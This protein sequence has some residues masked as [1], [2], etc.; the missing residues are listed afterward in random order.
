MPPNDFNNIVHSLWRLPTASSSAVSFS[1]FTLLMS[2]PQSSTSQR[3]KL[4]WPLKADYIKQVFPLSSGMLTSVPLFT[5]AFTTFNRLYTQ[6]KCNSFYPY[7]PAL[8]FTT[9]SELFTIS[10]A[11]LSEASDLSYNS[12]L[13]LSS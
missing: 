12:F 8:L 1:L 11:S 10:I 5:N 4:E 3:H 6:A 2:A 9:K 7:L 13:I